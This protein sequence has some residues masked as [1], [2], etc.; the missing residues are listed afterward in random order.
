MEFSD[1]EELANRLRR[2]KR[3]Q[4]SDI[5]WNF[6]TICVILATF[7]LA[8]ILMMVYSN[9]YIALNPFPPPTMPVLVMLP[10]ATPTLVAMPPTWTPSPKPS[11]TPQSATVTL[12][13][14]PSATIVTITL[15]ST[16][17]VTGNPTYTFALQGVP[18][19]LRSEVYKPDTGCTWQGVAGLVVDMQGQHL[20]NISIV[21]KGT[22]NGKTVSFQTIS[23][24]HTEY[25]ESGYEFPL[26]RTPIESI[27]LLSIQLMDEAR[28]PMSEQVIFD[29]YGTC[30]KNLVLINFK[31]I[32]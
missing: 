32:R 1:H 21:L 5:F 19:G 18:T 27:G 24:T 15:T 12:T 13:P 25:G 23:G 3:R 2:R 11:E 29:T 16:A 14:E 9:P 22:Y 8:A 4:R 30:D 20:V 26:G 28:Q 7:A 31:K 6:L 10:T 17:V